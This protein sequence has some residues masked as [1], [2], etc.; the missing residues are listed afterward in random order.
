MTKITQE[1]YNKMVN[2]R[3]RG[4]TYNEIIK[5]LN[6]SKWACINY[7]KRIKPDKSFIEKEWEKA[8]REAE[9]VLKKNGFS[10][11]VN[12]NKISPSSYWDYYAERNQ[13]KW[14]IDVTVNKQKD[15]LSKVY[16]TVERYSHAIL[17]KNNNNWEFIEINFKKKKLNLK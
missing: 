15:I 11:L 2:L 6:I 1:L 8:E 17:I 12:L 13:K 5:T 7:L 16:H 4:A 3:K 9:K 14:L 10:H